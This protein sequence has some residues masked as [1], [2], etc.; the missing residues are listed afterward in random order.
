MRRHGDLMVVVVVGVSEAGGHETMTKHTETGEQIRV[1][2]S[3]YP[4]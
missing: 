4:V 2:E 3:E 1:G